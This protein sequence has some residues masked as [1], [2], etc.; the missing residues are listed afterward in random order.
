M[1]TF[2]ILIYTEGDISFSVKYHTRKMRI[3]R[4]VNVNYDNSTP[5]EIFKVH[6]RD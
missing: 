2:C 4:N 5:F 6:A 3:V 1:I